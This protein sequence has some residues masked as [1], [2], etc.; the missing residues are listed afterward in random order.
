MR[1]SEPLITWIEVARASTR[2]AAAELA[3]VLEAVGVSSGTAR[4]GAEHIVIVRLEDV[5]RA[6]TELAKYLSENRGWP[7]QPAVPPPIS[8]GFEAAALFVVLLGLAYWTQAQEAFGLDWWAAGCA[9]ASLI[10]NGA[11][12][13]S[14]TALTLH[15]DVLHLAGNALFGALFG[16]MLSQSVG[17]GTAWLAFV[18]TGAIGN[19]ANA[20]VQA[21]SHTS[22]GA[23]TAVF[24]MLGVQVAH[25]WMRR[26]QLHYSRWRRWAPLV[27]GVALLAWLGGG[28]ER[29]DPSD[30][31][32]KL[33]D[34]DVPIHRIDVGAHVS[35]FAAG[36]G[37]GTLLGRGKS[38]FAS[39]R[40]AQASIAVL[41]VVAMALAWVVAFR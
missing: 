30:L 33:I 15:A 24:G 7:K 39:G 34:L 20:W 12:W 22:I 27:I 5:V 11:W 40:A 1:L 31:S 3:L 32:K 18:V 6:R 35:G 13:R 14:L 28:A 4:S 10:R 8:R 29:V 38:V 37:L 23:S 25:D 36:L 21:P 26:K 9:D 16:V 19:W 41:A 17:S 2:E